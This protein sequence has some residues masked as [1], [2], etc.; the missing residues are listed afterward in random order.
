MNKNYVPGKSVNGNKLQENGQAA[1]KMHY[2]P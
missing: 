1:K 2:K